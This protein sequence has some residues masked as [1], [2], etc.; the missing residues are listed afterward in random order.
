M[1][2]STCEIS[3]VPGFKLN[4]YQSLG[5]DFALSFFGICKLPLSL[6]KTQVPLRHTYIREEK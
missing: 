4:I 2:L 3:I 5:G 1:I 6:Q